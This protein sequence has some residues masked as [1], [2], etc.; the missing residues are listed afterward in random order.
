MPGVLA[1]AA[2]ILD[3]CQALLGTDHAKEDMLSTVP[4]EGTHLIITATLR[5]I[6]ILHWCKKLLVEPKYSDPK[7]SDLNIV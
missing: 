3:V 4:R 2:C 7:S 1:S 5:S 6:P